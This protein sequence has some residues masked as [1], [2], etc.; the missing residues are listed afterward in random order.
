MNTSSL[1]TRG[2]G[3][4]STDRFGRLRRAEKEVLSLPARMAA[5]FGGASFAAIAR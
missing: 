3:S 2:A 4:A 1:L 5:R